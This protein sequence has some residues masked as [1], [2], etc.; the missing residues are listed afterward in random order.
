MDT[1]TLPR[2]EKFFTTFNVTEL[3]DGNLLTGINTLAAMCCTLATVARPGSGIGTAD[4]RFFRIGTSL[5]VSGA[6]SAGRVTDEVLCEVGL[7][8]NNYTKHLQRH[9]QFKEQSKQSPY[10]RSLLGIPVDQPAETIVS[11]LPT[12]GGLYPG[13]L[14]NDWARALENPPSEGTEPGADVPKFFF[15]A[16]RPKDLAKR[17]SGLR[18]G[19]PLVHL[20][21]NRPSDLAGFGETAESLLDGC[22]SV[23]AGAE[24][25]Q[26]QLLVTDSLGILGEAARNPEDGMAWIARL[27]WLCDNDAGPE[28][29]R[30]PAWENTDPGDSLSARFRDALSRGLANRLRGGG[31]KPQITPAALAGAQHHWTEFLKKMERSLPG[32]SGAARN[33]LATLCFGLVEISRGDLSR[34]GSAIGDPSASG[35]P[36][37]SQCPGRRKLEFMVNDVEAFARFLVFRMANARAAMLHSAEL[38]RRQSQ[39]RRVFQ[40]L[41]ELPI[42]ARKV[43]QHLNLKADDCHE[44]LRWLEASNLA[45]NSTAGWRRVEGAELSFTG[46]PILTL[47][48]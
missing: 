3:G 41:G 31:M 28:I 48:A 11:E 23:R 45:S 19:Q 1:D 40:K 37:R 42:E 20:A 21:V 14:S 16:N 25:V 13:A 6:A 34:P 43:Y 5:L 8:Q 32:I 4:G 33:L 26:G 46:R 36:A 2:L 12:D 9:Q 10:D 47:E 15:A 44:C 38:T 7:R 27:V 18:R 30:D 35:L 22:L 24:T 17:L 29:Q 39:I